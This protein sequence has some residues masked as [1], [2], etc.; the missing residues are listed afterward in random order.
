MRKV[1]ALVLALGVVTAFHAG[2]EALP[3]GQGGFVLIDGQAFDVPYEEQGKRVWAGSADDPLVFVH[4]DGNGRLS[5]WAAGNKDPALAY[6]L[7]ATDAGAPS[8]FGLFFVIPMVPPVGAPNGAAAAIRG[9]LTDAAG[10][11]VSIVPSF[12]S[13]QVSN[14]G[15]PD[16]NLGV[17]VGGPA[18]FGPGLP[19]A[20]YDYGPFGAG[21]VPGPGPGP[22]ESLATGVVFTLSGGDD[23]GSLAGSVG[24]GRVP[25]PGPAA[26]LL[27]G[28]GLLGIG[29]AARRRP[30]GRRS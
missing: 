12:G 5:L 8:V 22:W 27:V 17:D 29:V 26:A 19:G 16:T 14:L 4:P 1:A 21:P 13:V 23:V 3:V 11:G 10:D 9:R 7:T 24:F 18:A 30:F 20:S 2:A 25:V 6:V 15:A 28:C